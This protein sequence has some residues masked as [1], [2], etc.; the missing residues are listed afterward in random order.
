MRAVNKIPAKNVPEATPPIDEAVLVPASAPP[1][2]TDFPFTFKDNADLSCAAVIP[3]AA[4]AAGDDASASVKRPLEIP[5]EMAAFTRDVRIVSDAPTGRDNRALLCAANNCTPIAISSPPAASPRFPNP[6]AP[7]SA[8]CRLTDVLTLAI[9]SSD[10]L[11][12][13]VAAT[14]TRRAE[15]TSSEKEALLS[16][17]PSESIAILRMKVRVGTTDAVAVAVEKGCIV[18]AV[19]VA[20]ITALADD[21]PIAVIVETAL[22]EGTMIVEVAIDDVVAAPVKTALDDG[23]ADSV[24]GTAVP[25]G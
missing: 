10:V 7:R 3:S 16:G 25:L 13:R 21:E 18:P 14:P 24:A 23:T 15:A 17:E 22:E 20:V 19:A 1:T 6:N 2:S 5:S 4:R 8:S 11:T 12:P 9:T